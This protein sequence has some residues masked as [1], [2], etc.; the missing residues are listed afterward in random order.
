[1][2][3]FKTIKLKL[4]VSFQWRL[5]GQL[6]GRLTITSGIIILRLWWRS[7]PGGQGRG[8]RQLDRLAGVGVGRRQS[9]QEVREI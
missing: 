5:P 4:M 6:P 2:K 8:R 3:I 9:G 7:G 1:M